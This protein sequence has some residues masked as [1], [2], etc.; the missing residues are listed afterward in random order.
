LNLNKVK[1]CSGESITFDISNP[2]PSNINKVIYYTVVGS[3]R[4]EFGA[5][6]KPNYRFG[7]VPLNPNFPNGTIVTAQALDSASGCGIFSNN[8]TI[9]VDPL[10]NVGFTFAKAN[11]E[12][13]LTDTSSNT[14]RRNWIID[15]DTFP[16]TNKVY[17]HVFGTAGSK[18]ILMDGF[19]AN[20]C[21]GSLS[22]PVNVV[23]TGLQNATNILGM[24]LFPN[25]ANDKVTIN[26]GES[27]GQLQLK[28][29]DQLGKLLLIKEVIKGEQ[30]DLKS[31]AAGVYTVQL[32]SDDKQGQ[33]RLVIGN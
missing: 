10:P 22:L 26:W 30:L 14:V 4:I 21:K 32:S 17:R 11:L 7:P 18:V 19:T 15:G 1:Y 29:Y 33:I 12:V 3:N 13:E 28:I 31:F 23:A 5:K 9:S 2:I 25:P 16:T 8:A 27:V 24:Q 20:D 6:A